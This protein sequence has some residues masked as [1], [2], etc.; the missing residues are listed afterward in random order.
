MRLGAYPTKIREGS[1]LADCYKVNS[2]NE[3]H[4]HRFEFNNKYRQLFEEAG[5]RLTGLSPDEKL[6]EAVELDVRTHPFFIGT[7]YH[8]EFKSRPLSPHPVFAR[9]I[10]KSAGL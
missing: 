5:L 4:R 3:R 2:V 10:E 6:V 8:P 7:Q 1:L 9:F